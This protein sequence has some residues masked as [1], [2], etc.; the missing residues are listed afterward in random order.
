MVT[1]ETQTLPPRRRGSHTP[2]AVRSEF[3]E[4]QPAAGGLP[5]PG[6][7]EPQLVVDTETTNMPSADQRLSGLT[8]REWGRTLRAEFEPSRQRT[9]AGVLATAS[10]GSQRTGSSLPIFLPRGLCTEQAHEVAQLIDPIRRSP[11]LA[12]PETSR[13]AIET[14]ASSPKDVKTSRRKVI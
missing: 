2:G 12:P 8:I 9:L 4:R 11:E 1:P 7:V 6:G 10:A 3:H 14:V 13:C 5:T